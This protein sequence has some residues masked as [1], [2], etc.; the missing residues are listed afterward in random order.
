MSSFLQVLCMDKEI[1]CIDN[2]D[3]LSY[4]N[5][6]AIVLYCINNLGSVC[7]ML[8]YEVLANKMSSIKCSFLIYQILIINSAIMVSLQICKYSWNLT[9]DQV[10]L[11]IFCRS[12]C[13]AVF[14]G[15]A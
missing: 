3:N 11:F 2:T 9:W 6:I 7:R 13:D 5:D 14:E 10:Y 15:H 8:L 4:I 12:F 1:Y